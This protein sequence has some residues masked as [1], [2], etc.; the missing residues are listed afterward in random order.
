[1]STIRRALVLVLVLSLL[2]AGVSGGAVVAGIMGDG[3]SCS[4]I[5]AAGAGVPACVYG[6]F[7]FLV[8]AAVAY[9]ALRARRWPENDEY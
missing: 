1:M 9:F 7:T 5:A 6:A 3:S 4:W 8:I 2:G